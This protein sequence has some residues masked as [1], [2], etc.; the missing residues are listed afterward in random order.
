MIISSY[1]SEVFSVFLPFRVSRRKCNF[2]LKIENFWLRLTDIYVRH[3]SVKV[4]VSAKYDR[5]E[6]EHAPDLEKKRPRTLCGLETDPL[7][8]SVESFEHRDRSIFWNWYYGK[9]MRKIFREIYWIINWKEY[10]RFTGKNR[11]KFDRSFS[12][13]VEQSKRSKR[14]EFKTDISWIVCRKWRREIASTSD[15][16]SSYWNLKSL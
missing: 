3:N 16:V 9:K 10:H 2:N 11:L 8:P 15:N 13:I 12:W 7:N 4:F 6:I 14:F 5:F 1:E